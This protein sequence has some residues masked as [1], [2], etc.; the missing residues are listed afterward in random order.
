MDLRSGYPFWQIKNG[1]LVTFPPLTGDVTCDVVV[2][3][4]G[5]TGA[6]IAH[7][8]CKE[9]VN[10]VVIDKRDIAWGS[11]SASTAMLQYEIDK[12]LCEL[13]PLVGEDQAV[14]SYQLGVMAIEQ[15]AAIAAQLGSAAEFR[16]VESV[17]ATSSRDEAEALQAEYTARRQAG[18]PVRWVEQD[19][20]QRDFGLVAHAAIVSATAAKL[21]PYQ[22]TYL[23]F[24]DL[25]ARGGQV[26]DR[27]EATKLE[28]GA[29]R[30][31][32]QTNRQATI[33]AKRIVFATGYESKQYLKQKVADLHATYALVTEPMDLSHLQGQDYLFWETARPY[34]Y[35]RTTADHR[36]VLGGG[37][38]PFRNPTVRDRLIGKKVEEL[39]KAHRQFYP[40]SPELEVAYAWA[41][42]FGETKDGLA[43]IGAPPELPH[44]YFA[45]GYGGNGITY[46]M[47]AAGIIADLYM[48]RENL[49]AQL[50][51]FTR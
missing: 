29:N 17:Y 27:T 51:S 8:L 33:R 18:L 3:G 35:L 25:V 44:A 14:R 48:G 7:T 47:I 26:F 38:L 23:L 19:E 6:L 10:V 12:E 42:T 1:L 9:G 22:F 5:I 32:V 41:G 16:R 31:T 24:A 43:Y 34:F 37:D 28:I 4:G 2:L 15:L 11:T 49:D 20:L 40:Q 45:L 13:I 21:D 30:V 46:S 50:F 36:L 39:R